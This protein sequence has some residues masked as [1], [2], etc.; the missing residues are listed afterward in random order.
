MWR[1]TRIYY[2]PIFIFNIYKRLES[3]ITYHFADDTNLLYFCK[4]IKELRKTVNTDL[5][6]LYD[7]LCA[8]RLS[9]NA[10]KTEF[11]VF[12]PPRYKILDRISSNLHHTKLFES[13]T[14]IT[15]Y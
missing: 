7:W 5:K 6:L 14:I 4:H 15:I 1:S 12:R 2:W 8:N 3:S 10:K 11:L 13:S 9:L